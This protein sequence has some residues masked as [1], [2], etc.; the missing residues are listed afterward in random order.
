MSIL[1]SFSD[2]NN[3]E[4]SLKGAI[5]PFKPVLWDVKPTTGIRCKILKLINYH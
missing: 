3:S 5:A 4:A 1:I 2:D